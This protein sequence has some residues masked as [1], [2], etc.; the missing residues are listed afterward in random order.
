MHVLQMK[1]WLRL[2]LAMV[3]LIT[4]AIPAGMFSSKADAADEPLTVAQ[5]IARNN[6]GLPGTVEGYVIGYFNNNS[7][8]QLQT[9]APF[10]GGSN[11]GIADTPETDLSK[12]MSVQIPNETSVRDI[13][14][15]NKNP[16]LFG[17]K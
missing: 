15:L 12:I 9:E 11:F 17:K 4:G 8:N 16:E 7:K 13:F 10:S 1:R 3:L 2:F 5:A 14:G 6:D